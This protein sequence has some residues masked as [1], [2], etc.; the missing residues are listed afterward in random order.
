LPERERRRIFFAS[1]K[2]ADSAGRTVELAVIPPL[3]DPRE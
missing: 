3:F 2:S 1:G